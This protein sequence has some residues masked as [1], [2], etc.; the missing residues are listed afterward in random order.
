MPR[1]LKI[2]GINPGT[3]Y[4]GVA[5]FEGGE[6]LDWGVKVI[7]GK[8]SEERTKMAKKIVSLL[9][10][11]GGPEVLAIKLLHPARSSKNLKRLVSQIKE[12]SKRRGLKVY[13]YSIKEL[14]D[15]FSPE[16]KIN[17][18]KLAEIVALE[19]PELLPELEK[20]KSHKNPY[21][22][23]MFEAIALGSMCFH[24]LDR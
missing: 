19:Y 22:M 17:K 24:H 10:D 2:L 15:F 5:I 18:R 6:L 3:R 8:R 14:E 23:R 21:H 12:L 4:L 11:C 9:I 20:E 16:E 1:E 7:K 13:Q